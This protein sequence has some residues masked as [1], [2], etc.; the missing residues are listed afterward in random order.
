M[1]TKI[2]FTK[3]ILILSVCANAQ[4]LKPFNITIN[5]IKDRYALQTA[6]VD[7]ANAN[8]LQNNYL[9]YMQGPRRQFDYYDANVKKMNSQET[10]DFY[11]NLFADNDILFFGEMHVYALP[12]I[13]TMNYIEEYNEYAK[14]NGLK[15]VTHVLWERSQNYERVL[16]NVKARQNKANSLEEKLDVC[17]AMADEAYQN[18]DLLLAQ[19]CR[20][21]AKGVEVICAD[22]PKD[23]KNNDSYIKDTDI[24]MTDKEGMKLRNLHTIAHMEASLAGGGK[25]AAFGGA[26]H[27]VYGDPHKNPSLPDLALKIFPKHK[28][29]SVYNTGGQ[30]ESEYWPP[31]LMT[32]RF[33]KEEQPN[34]YKRVYYKGFF[35]FS[36]YITNDTH[37]VLNIIPPGTKNKALYNMRPADIMLLIKRDFMFSDAKELIMR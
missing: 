5:E 33:E 11:I 25:V 13:V 7:L 22:T 24:G 17:R 3:I 6:A 36:E 26:M 27:M 1:K 37:V 34:P 20:L 18:S 30:A 29:I 31:S 8:K 15:P 19:T 4:A 9:W 21:L 35:I 23:Y 2:I 32:G 16:N 12:H 28:I 14:L 10:K